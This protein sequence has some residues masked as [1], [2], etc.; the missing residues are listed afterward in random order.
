MT[1]VAMAM[2]CGASV[3]QVPNAPKMSKERQKELCSKSATKIWVEFTGACIPKN[4]CKDS[5]YEG[6][7]VR[8]FKDIQVADVATVKSIVELY[9]KKNGANCNKFINLN[10]GMGFQGANVTGQDYFACDMNGRY[11][12]FEFDDASENVKNTANIGK[13]KAA[14]LAVG[15]TASGRGKNSL[16][17]AAAPAVV[18]PIIGGAIAV[19][20]VALE[21][22][23][24][25]CFGISQSVCNEVWQ[26]AAW[27]KDE[28]VCI[29]NFSSSIVNL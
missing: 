7:C 28:N 12:A 11:I 13:N 5:S 4:P 20:N 10:D 25:A 16:V 17:V 19:S 8:L 3:A 2:V 9:A 23:E 22:K 14:C 29:I 24:M 18:S 27:S 26:N 21:D 6:Y 15:G 1:T